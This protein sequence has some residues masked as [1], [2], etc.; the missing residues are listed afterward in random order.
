[1]ARQGSVEWLRSV[2]DAA[3]SGIL[4]FDAYGNITEINPAAERLFGYRSDDLAGRNLSLL[5]QESDRMEVERHLQ[6]YLRDGD[7]ERFGRPR[8]VQGRRANGEAFPLL[9]TLGEME[10]GVRR[11]FVG[12]AEDITR[13][14]EAESELAEASVRLQGLIAFQNAILDAADFSIVSTDRD[15]VIR[16]F[17]AGAERGLGYKAEELVDKETPAV[18][19]VAEE[20]V[21]R[22]EAL[23]KE[24]G[25]KI[26]PGFEVF[27]AKARRGVPDENEWTYVRKDGSTYPVRLSV[28]A[29]RDAEGGSPASSAWGRTSRTRRRRGK[30][31]TASSTCR[32]TC[33]A[34]PAW[35][36]TS[37]A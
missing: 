19:H 16:S 23:S 5:L 25:T 27:V 30:R 33:S 10:A 15:G 1:M 34:S 6:T 35:M 4:T 3:G 17:N 14:K 12:I 22:A 9:L 29:V 13:L 11:L 18:I 37:S 7:S 8:E 32:S 28:T 20:V 36:G 26:E 24:L 21:A 31:W 2:V